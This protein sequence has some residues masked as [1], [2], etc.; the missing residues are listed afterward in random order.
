M[1]FCNF[2]PPWKKSFRCPCPR[3]RLKP[4]DIL[5]RGKI[6]NFLLYLTTKYVFENF[7]GQLPDCS[8][9]VAGFPSRATCDPRADCVKPPPYLFCTC[10]SCKYNSHI[11]KK[12]VFL[13]TLY[14]F[15]IQVSNCQP[16]VSAIP[17]AYLLCSICCSTRQS[18]S[19]TFLQL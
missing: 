14:A 15:S 13:R 7:R 18:R 3:A 17:A 9:L 12:R 1:K 4:A 19:L 5:G 16:W 10:S 6:C 8:L 2:W 11:I